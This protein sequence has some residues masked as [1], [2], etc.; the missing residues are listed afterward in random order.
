M[1]NEDNPTIIRSYE[2][3][4]LPT[5]MTLHFR[6]NPVWQLGHFIGSS[7]GTLAM[8]MKGHDKKM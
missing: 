6:K 3:A 8:V 5:R 4:P 7:I 1:K 2:D